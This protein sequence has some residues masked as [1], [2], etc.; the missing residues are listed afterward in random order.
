[1]VEDIEELEAQLDAHAF[2]HLRVLHEG[3]VEVVE[4]GPSHQ[5][6]ARIALGAK[7]RR[8]EGA[9]AEPHVPGAGSR[10]LIVDRAC[11]VGNVPACSTSTVKGNR[12]TWRGKRGQGAVND[13]QRE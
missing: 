2:R 10:V 6:S 1:M 8:R 4:A 12:K 9:G 13:V 11:Q 3:E 5:I 7:R